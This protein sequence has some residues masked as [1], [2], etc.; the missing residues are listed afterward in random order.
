MA[1]E[2]KPKEEVAGGKVMLPHPDPNATE[3]CCDECDA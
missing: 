1:Q 3:D 2:Q